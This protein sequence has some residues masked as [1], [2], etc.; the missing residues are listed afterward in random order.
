MS[1][2][3]PA[4]LAIIPAILL[5]SACASSTEGNGTAYR[6]LRIVE[7]SISP[8]QIGAPAGATIDIDIGVV[9]SRDMNVA[10]PTAGIDP[11]SVPAARLNRF[12]RGGVE[13]ELQK[14]HVVLGPLSRGRYEIV[15]LSCTRNKSTL[16][17]V[18]DAE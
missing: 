17:L 9:G 5:L 12:T 2:K 8:S 18:G 11:V 16:L 13:P 14:R 7:G 1:V 15:C 3:N 4:W 10:V 6:S